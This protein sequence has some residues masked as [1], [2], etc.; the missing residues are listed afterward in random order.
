MM[1]KSTVNINM[2]ALVVLPK[3]LPTNSGRLAPPLR[4]DSIPLR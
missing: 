2:I 3:Y 1:S 4:M